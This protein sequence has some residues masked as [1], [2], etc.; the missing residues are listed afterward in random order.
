MSLIDIACIT[1]L[2]LSFLIPIL[3]GVLNDIFTGHFD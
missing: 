2:I 3:R 1:V